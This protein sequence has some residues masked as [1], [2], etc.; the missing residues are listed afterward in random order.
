MNLKQTVSI[1]IILILGA[2]AT[3]SIVSTRSAP[4][5]T[6][7]QGHEAAEIQDEEDR[8]SSAANEASAPRRGPRGGR[9][10]VQDDFAL[11][12]TIYESGVPPEFRIFA[13][14]KDRPLDPDSFDVEVRLRRLG[15]DAEVI[16]FEPVAEY[17][18]GLAEI[19]EPHSFVVE[20][21]ARY[22]GKSFAFSYA[23]E[24]ARVHMADAEVERANIEI[25]PAG[26]RRI[27]ETLKLAG[28]IQLDRDRLAHV[29]SPLDGIVVSVHANAG[30]LVERGQ[31]LATISSQALARLRSAIAETQSRVALTAQTAERE[32]KL[33][34]EGISP[35]QDFHQAEHDRRAAQIAAAS[36]REQLEAIGLP[37]EYRGNPAQFALL[38]STDGTVIDK[39]LVVGESVSPETPVFTLADLSTVWAEAKVGSRDIGRVAPGQPARVQ[40]SAQAL[41]STGSVSYISALL[42]ESDRAVTVRVV[43]PNPGGRWRPGLP[44]SIDLE[45]GAR[46]VPVA[47]ARTGLQTV[48]DWQ[49]VFG[50]YG[51]VFEAR[52]LI[53]GV[54]DDDWIEVTKGLHAGERY[55]AANSYVI[56]ADIGKAGASHDH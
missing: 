35:E 52:P 8:P 44:V 18:R 49:V 19:V 11:E 2:L 41:V 13:D 47:V 5:S 6:A 7:E 16:R 40:A 3:Y 53:L 30:E 17:R 38:A 45:T 42:G 55:A 25:L 37:L 51:E 22:E 28:E 29:V 26:P 36:A 32:K 43:L 12:A 34:Q 33:W 54:S 56:K 46:E 15:Q 31:L 1:L 27:A 24:E 9:L 10:F 14:W 39:H 21:S 20:I 4:S 48:R 23:Q 50:R